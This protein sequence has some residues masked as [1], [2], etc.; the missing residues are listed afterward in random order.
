MSP[1]VSVHGNR[2]H[3]LLTHSPSLLMLHRGA[4]VLVDGAHA[5]GSLPLSMRCSRPIK[6][7]SPEQ[8]VL[9]LVGGQNFSAR[10]P[11]HW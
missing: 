6:N 7:W 8:N 4:Q 9:V 11:S 2:H 1:H 10:T 3:T 5:L